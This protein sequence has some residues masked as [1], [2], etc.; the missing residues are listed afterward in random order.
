ML[1]SAPYHWSDWCSGCH[2]MTT[3]W[4]LFSS[5][6]LP[7]GSLS[8]EWKWNVVYG[9]HWQKKEVQYIEVKLTNY[10]CKLQYKLE[11]KTL[12]WIYF[13][14]AQ[15]WYTYNWKG[16]TMWFLM[17]PKFFVIE[18]PWRYTCTRFSTFVLFHQKQ[19]PGPLIRPLNC[20]RI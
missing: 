12:N 14:V 8:R 6:I 16:N 10:Y 11:L 9:K 5:W 18:N 2:T 1:G 3:P 20:F 7:L 4:R 13:A 19:A 15:K 17:P